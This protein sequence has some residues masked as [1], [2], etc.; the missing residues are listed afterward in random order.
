[1]PIP[2]I[3]PIHSRGRRHFTFACR[4]YVDMNGNSVRA[5]FKSVFNCVDK[6]FGVGVGG[7]IQCCRRDGGSVRYPCRYGD[8]RAEEA[9]MSEHGVGAPSVTLSTMLRISVIPSIGPTV[10]P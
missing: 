4:A 9:Q 2:C 6:H 7:S 1:M 10:T 5:H 8:A 3:L